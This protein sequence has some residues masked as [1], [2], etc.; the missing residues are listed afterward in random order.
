[1]LFFLLAS[2]SFTIPLSKSISA[3]LLGAASLYILIAA[4]LDPYSRERA[5]AG[6]KGPLI[7][8]LFLYT[9]VLGLGLFF[10]EDIMEGLD[11]VRSA[12]QLSL[13][14]FAVSFFL[15]MENGEGRD[16]RR[17]LLISSFLAG[18]L[19]LDSLGLMEYLGLIGERKYQILRPL[20][21]HHI[22]FGNLNAVALYG[23]LALIFFQPGKY[24]LLGFASVLLALPSVLF[25][26]SRAVWF[27]IIITGTASVLLLSGRRKTL[28][29]IMVLVLLA[30]LLS[31]YQGS[32]VF[33]ERM[34]QIGSDIALFR[35][36]NAETSL[37]MRF[38]MWE[39]ALDIFFSNPFFGAGTGDYKL[40]IGRMIASGEAPAFLGQYNQPHNVYL[41]LL[42]TTGLPGLF[43]YLF[44]FYRGMRLSISRKKS[45]YGL[46]AFAV[47]LHYLIAGLSDTTS[48]QMIS[49]ALALV[50]G[51]CLFKE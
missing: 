25:A 44:I 50:L 13:I 6:L 22:W 37:G 23:A 43:A 17:R 29:F 12:F 49:Y 35:S 38:K 18:M 33:R 47:L 21:M 2:F 19:I 1:V 42:A 4:F 3:I 26:E 31:F 11:K 51:V 32:D 40:L 45:L 30:G 5:R 36:G 46:L 16:E 48:T 15:H 27:G 39:A 34:D 9:A 14:Y 7:N 24:K 28:F 41:F 10:S 20:G 8:A